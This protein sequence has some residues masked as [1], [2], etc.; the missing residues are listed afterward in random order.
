MIVG[1][2]P[3]LL[4]PLRTYVQPYIFHVH[5]YIKIFILGQV[6]FN[7]DKNG[8][9]DY[10]TNSPGHTGSETYHAFGKFGR[11]A[12]LFSD[13]GLLGRLAGSSGWLAVEPGN[14]TMGTRDHICFSNN[15]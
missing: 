13:R 1:L 8:L 2:A 6:T 12:L 10:F 7:V 4:L 15:V 14:E 11:L 3:G 9:D 5:T